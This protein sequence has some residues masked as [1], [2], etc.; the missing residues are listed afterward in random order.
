MGKKDETELSRL[1]QDLVDDVNVDRERLVQFTDELINEYSGDRA[2]GIAE[3]VGKLTDAMTR[4]HQVKVAT[5]KALAK[6][7][8][9]EPNDEDDD[10]DFASEIGPAFNAAVDEGSN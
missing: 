1:V 4:Q 7:L 10:E 6:E 8:S 9:T 2:A 3:Y 5:I